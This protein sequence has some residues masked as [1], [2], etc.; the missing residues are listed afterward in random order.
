MF[1][2]LTTLNLNRTIMLYCFLVTLLLHAI[3]I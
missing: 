2:P 1:V 3:I